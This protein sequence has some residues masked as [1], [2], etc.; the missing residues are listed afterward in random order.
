MFHDLKQDAQEISK[1]D[2]QKCLRDRE[3]TEITQNTF[4]RPTVLL[5][6]AGVG[7]ATLANVITGEETFTTLESVESMRREAKCQIATKTIDGYSYHFLLYDT[8]AQQRPT[9]YDAQTM[10]CF[11]TALE[12]QFKAGVGLLIF[13]LRHGQESDMEIDVFRFIIDSLQSSVSEC[14]VLVVTGCET[15][16]TEAK[17]AYKSKLYESDVTKHVAAFV[18]KDNIFL[19]SLPDIE[20]IDDELKE[21]YCKKKYTSQNEL[22]A[23]VQTPRILW[24][25]LELFKPEREEGKYTGAHGWSSVC[26]EKA[27]EG[28]M[29]KFLNYVRKF[30]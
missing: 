27:P 18:P 12:T 20:K 7:K 1:Q 3:L 4:L 10:R 2:A 28:A 5:G 29:T 19:V 11:K 13:V 6:R 23:L 30:Q 24:F 8:V 21:N 14:S 9:V 26:T 15:L 22:C 16:S 17:E 25:P